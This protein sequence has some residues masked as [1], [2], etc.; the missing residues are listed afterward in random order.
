MELS[1]PIV[2]GI[3]SISGVVSFIVSLFSTDIVIKSVTIAGFIIFALAIS[4]SMRFLIKEYILKVCRWITLKVVIIFLFGIIIGAA[5]YP[6]IL[7]PTISFAFTLVSPKIE[8]LDS[9]PESGKCLDSVDSIFMID[10]K[11]P[12]PWPY[13]NF[14]KV[15]ISRDTSIDVDWSSNHQILRIKS[16]QIF[17]TNEHGGINFPRF[18]FDTSY[19]IVVE[20]PFLS[21]PIMLKFS[22]PKQ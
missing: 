11:K 15:N 12:I 20:G 3:S 19:D 21:T 5:S 18:E 13:Y 10:F 16:N 9:R 6:L 14:V 8:L 17:P 22:T 4:S 2:S 1:N 7:Q